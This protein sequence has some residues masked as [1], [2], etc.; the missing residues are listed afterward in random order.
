MRN[1]L[2]KIGT[3]RNYKFTAF[4]KRYGFRKNNEAT[5]LLLYIRDEHNKLVTGHAWITSATPFKE[6]GLKEGDRVEFVSKVGVY[7]KQGSFGTEVDY[8]LE[9]PSQVCKIDSPTQDIYK[10]KIQHDIVQREE[11]NEKRTK[12]VRRKYQRNI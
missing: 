12:K 3:S 2:R 11:T 10:K 4:F 8:N 7:V 5:V 6:I 9:A 1:C